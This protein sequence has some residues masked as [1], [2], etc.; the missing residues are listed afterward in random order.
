MICRRSEESA[1]LD[2]RRKAEEVRMALLRS[3][4]TGMARKTRTG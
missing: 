4:S 2:H 3:R 1:S